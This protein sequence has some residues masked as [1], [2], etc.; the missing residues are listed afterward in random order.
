MVTLSVKMDQTKTIVSVLP[1]SLAV[2]GEDACWQQTCAT[3]KS[4]VLMEMTKTIVVSA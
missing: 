1:A 4:T 3:E 2:M